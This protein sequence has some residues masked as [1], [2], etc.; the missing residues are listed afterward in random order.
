MAASRSQ[1]PQRPPLPQPE[2]P[3]IATFVDQASKP[4][5][6]ALFADLR[7]GLGAMKGPRAEQARKVTK[8]I[9][10]TEELLSHLLQVREKI[11]SNRKGKR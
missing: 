1:E 11:A 3:A 9:E 10:R 4:E 2:Y 8:A 5:V 7:D 6:E